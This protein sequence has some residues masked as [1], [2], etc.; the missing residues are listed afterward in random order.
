MATITLNQIIKQIELLATAHKQIKTVNNGPFDLFL[1]NADNVYPACHFDVSSVSLSGKNL[2][3]GVSFFFMDRV[4]HEKTNELDVFS[5]QLS[6]AHDIISQLQYD[7]FP[8]QIGTNVPMEMFTDSTPDLLGGVKVDVTF[9]IPYLSDRCAVPSTYFFPITDSSINYPNYPDYISSKQYVDNHDIVAIDV[10]GG[11]TKTITLT[12]GDG[13]TLSDTFTGGG[14]GESLL[15]TARNESGATMTK[16]TIVYLSGASGNKPLMVKAQANT[17]MT[18]TATF[19]IVQNDIINNQNGTVVVFGDLENVDTFGIS[20]GT[21]LWLSPTTAGAWTTTKP[22]APNHAVVIGIVA[23]SHQ[24]QGIVTVR[25][26]NG[27][28]LQ[29]LHNV[30]ISGLVDG[31]FLR[32]NATSTLWENATISTSNIYNSDGTLTGNRTVALSTFT[33]EFSGNKFSASDVLLNMNS[34]S[35]FI[36]HSSIPGTPGKLDV[37]GKTKIRYTDSSFDYALTITG[38]RNVN[39]SGGNSYLYINP[40]INDNN[41]SNNTHYQFL[42]I[43]PIV[44]SLVGG[45][46]GTFNH[47]VNISPQFST[48]IVTDI[49]VLNFLNI[50]PIIS[51]YRHFGLST[52]VRGI[53]I[54]PSVTVTGTN[55]FKSIENVIGDNFFNSTSG[56]TYIGYS[57]AP[58]GSYKFAVNGTSLFND[59]LLVYKNASNFIGLYPQAN[60]TPPY[61]R[62]FYSGAIDTRI[63]ITSGT[64]LIGAKAVQSGFGFYQ[65]GNTTYVGIVAGTIGAT[66]GMIGVTNTGADAL[67]HVASPNGFSSFVSFRETGAAERGLIGFANGSGDMQIRVNGA[68]TM[69]TGTNAATFYSTGA[70]GIGTTATPSYKF[71]VNG[72]ARFNNSVVA[73]TVSSINVLDIGSIRLGDDGNGRYLEA[74]NG[75]FVRNSNVTY[76][77]N[78]LQIG[79]DIVLLRSNGLLNLAANGGTFGFQF[80]SVNTPST[81]M[82]KFMKQRNDGVKS[83]IICS[84]DFTVAT[85]TPVHLYIYGGM[86]T[87]A[88]NMANLI[89]QH[90]GTNDRGIVAIGT[91]SPNAS[92]KLQIDSTTKGFLI[93]RMTTTNR[94]NISTPAVGLSIY[95]TTTNKIETWDGT[96]WNAHW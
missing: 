33:L 11:T 5:D 82:L 49:A 69:I 30:A 58:T 41:S 20:E 6:I 23:R 70:V 29:E 83:A 59:D 15:Y 37:N 39:A 96:V 56:S 19:G 91:N 94:N 67:I 84:E 75:I 12:K 63:Y 46:A 35:T 72:T 66:G 92:A 51:G 52:N 65:A 68:T 32:Y 55:G 22:S 60:G 77:N 61:L 18:S 26:V 48:S 13:T 31:Q 21:T 93:P 38:I 7:D 42:S 16:G 4:L 9:D 43:Q 64:T 90:D 88:S 87:T 3:V 14:A 44:N 81:T 74:Y 36:G 10:T 62:M 79:N 73:Q 1:E 80:S 71:E 34:G 24:T 89:L 85:A 95:N 53:Y 28:E 27:F 54:N 2:S 50:S 25:I 40:T 8:F 45:I 17:E 76:P 78:Y 86:E 47:I 57:T